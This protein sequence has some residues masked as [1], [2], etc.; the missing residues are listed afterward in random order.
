MMKNTLKVFGLLSIGIMLSV[1]SFGQVCDK[2]PTDT[3]SSN[4]IQVCEGSPNSQSSIMRG[5]I[6]VVYIVDDVRMKEPTKLMVV[7]K[8]KVE[9][10]GESKVIQE[11]DERFTIRLCN[12]IPTGDCE[13][14]VLTF[15]D[16]QFNS[17]IESLKYNK[18]TYAIDVVI[19]KK[20]GKKKVIFPIE[21]RIVVEGNVAGINGT[22]DQG[23]Y[24]PK[25]EI[26]LIPVQATGTDNSI[27]IYPAK[28][29]AL[30]PIFNGNN[31][32][33]DVNISVYPNPTVNL[34][35][36]STTIPVSGLNVSVLASDGK[37]VIPNANRQNEGSLFTV[38]VANLSA[39][40]Y[41]LHLTGG[42]ILKTERFVKN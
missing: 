5:C 10:K 32:L 42:G 34:I 16:N 19:S 30:V 40:V 25:N 15:T 33:I 29:Y 13:K 11:T 39:G 4:L 14:M 12:V 8:P 22:D 28:N 41:Y 17:L 27:I 31:V 9:Q 21:W 37:M 20:A 6:A 7:E 3:I 26:D 23:V 38:D 35:N 2:V 1:S 36:I 18:N 24:S